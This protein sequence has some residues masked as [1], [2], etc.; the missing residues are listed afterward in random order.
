MFTEK[1]I[2]LRL[3]NEDYIRKTVD[4]MSTLNKEKKDEVTKQIVW[5]LRI[6]DIKQLQIKF[7]KIAGLVNDLQ[8]QM[9]SDYERT[10]NN[11]DAVLKNNMCYNCDI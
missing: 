11:C 5:F 2:E 9:L 3:Q 1:A 8:M 10:C 7:N 4:Q 6:K